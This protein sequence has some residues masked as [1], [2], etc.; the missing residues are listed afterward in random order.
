MIGF[1]LCPLK[2]LK[3]GV[4]FDFLYSLEIPWV[5]NIKLRADR[6]EKNQE[7]P[8]NLDRAEGSNS[9]LASIEVTD[10]IVG[11]CQK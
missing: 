6:L 9:G 1:F 7:C 2:V 8:K 4:A 11:F 5:E 3:I 10:A